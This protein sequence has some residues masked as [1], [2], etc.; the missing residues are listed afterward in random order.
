MFQ[1]RGVTGQKP[2]SRCTLT[3]ILLQVPRVPQETGT[4]SQMVSTRLLD[5]FK[6]MELA[7]G[8]SQNLDSESEAPD[9]Q[10]DP[11][12]TDLAS[13]QPAVT[14]PTSVEIMG[15]RH[16]DG[17][18][19]EDGRISRR[20][21]LY[22]SCVSG[23]TEACRNLSTLSLSGAPGG[24][25]SGIKGRW[26]ACHGQGLDL[27]P[28]FWLGRPAHLTCLPQFAS[29]RCRFILGTLRI[30]QRAG[31]IWQ[32]TSQ[33]PVLLSHMSVKKGIGGDA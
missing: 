7:G 28:S 1:G 31:R 33:T 24:G 12:S 6:A 23:G 22:G 30:W 3:A 13:W 10:S 15:P 18:G 14:Q 21:W 16:R 9:S 2:P 4:S 17:A 11:D 32:F 5:L 19:W 25:D 27:I 20:A 8:Q 26:G 29:R